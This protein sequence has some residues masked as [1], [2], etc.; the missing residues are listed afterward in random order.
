MRHSLRIFTAAIAA[1]AAI[2]GLVA[3]TLSGGAFSARAE[4][5]KQTADAAFSYIYGMPVSATGDGE[6]VYLLGDDGAVLDLYPDGSVSP[7]GGTITLVGA[8]SA[9]DADVIAVSESTAYLF[10]G[11]IIAAAVG[12]DGVYALTQDSLSLSDEQSRAKAKPE[13]D[14][15]FTSVASDGSVLYLTEYNKI[16]LKYFIYSFDGEKKSAI[17]SGADMGAVLSSTV[18]GD[19]LYIAT[20]G[21]LCSV[22]V[23]SALPSVKAEST[24]GA[25]IAVAS[26]DKPY[27]VTSSG[28]IYALGDSEPVGA[29]SGRITA[30]SRRGKIAYAEYAADEV[31]VVTASGSE[32]FAVP[33]PSAVA[34]GYSGTVYAAS[35]YAV[36][37]AESG[38]VVRIYDENV[39]D[40]CFDRADV[41]GE[42]PYVL[43]E[44]GTLYSPASDGTSIGT[45]IKHISSFDGGV[46]AVTDSAVLLYSP[47]DEDGGYTKTELFTAS[48]AEEIA[49]DRAENIFVLSGGNITKYSAGENGIYSDTENKTYANATS[50]II[51]ETEFGE[52]GFGDI[53]VISSDASSPSVTASEDAGTDMLTGGEY[54]EAYAAFIKENFTDLTGVPLTDDG[55]DIYVAKEDLQLYESPVEMPHVADVAKGSFLI[56]LTPVY[57]AESG[58]TTDYIYVASEQSDGIKTGF[59]N[60]RMIE[61]CAKTAYYDKNVGYTT[62]ELPLYKYPTSLLGGTDL[63]KSGV[64]VKVTLLPF[65]EEYRDGSGRAWSFVSVGEGADEVRGYIPSVYISEKS[66]ALA[67][68]YYNGEIR[69][70]DGIAAECYVLNGNKYEKSGKSV[71]DGTRVEIIG[72]Y[73]KAN[74]YTQVKYIDENGEVC[75][76]Y[77]LTSDV[78]QTEAGWYQV[79]MFIVAAVVVVFLIVLAIVFIRR[80][81][82]ID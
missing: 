35:G 20:D 54:D 57:M 16:T 25:A 55:A 8:D 71:A 7:F 30:S 14:C 10:G 45:G 60:I 19:V 34:I 40:I 17:L 61:E 73:T 23:R 32:R 21:G 42:V 2:L 44:S 38:E 78:I 46:L 22:D 5:G 76:C 37:K 13:T 43:T 47:S 49:A 75:E 62:Y 58:I 80:N 53:I 79:I 33:R 68:P 52:S 65:V 11:S 26:A 36:V 77:V 9:A 41:G 67:E 4:G 56:A 27:Y 15:V 31:T 64:N 74:E 24:F 12:S 3:L 39:T 63:K 51:N 29:Y 59:V 82:K 1:L 6:C 72:N 48:G 50:F 18:F 81:M 28:K 70:K 69:T 66:A